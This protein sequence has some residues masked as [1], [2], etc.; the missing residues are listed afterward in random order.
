MGID[1]ILERISVG[2][3]KE[4]EKITAEA[5][6]K[7]TEIYAERT[8]EAKIAAAAL[9]EAAEK[10]AIDRINHIK[11]T[12]ALES[13]KLVLAAKRDVINEV[14]DDIT[15]TFRKLPKDE[16]AA[17]L[18]DVAVKSS[19]KGT[20]FFANVDYDVADKVR[21][22]LRD[23]PQYK[24][25]KTTVKDISSGFIIKYENVR[26]DCSVESIV[27]NMKTELETIIASKLFPENT[28]KK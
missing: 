23:K 12:A 25:A 28:E 15:P 27:E 18:V 22:L 17:F 14:L 24:V 5:R 11:S 8:A 20:L 7:A 21:D 4:A 19:E 3:E 13:R 16:Y 10:D 2:S 9:I 6:A 26:I 1:N